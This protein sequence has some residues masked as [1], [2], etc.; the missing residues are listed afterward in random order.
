LVNRLAARLNKAYL[1]A[2]SNPNTQAYFLYTARGILQ[3]EISHALAIHFYYPSFFFITL[4]ITF[5]H[6][7]TR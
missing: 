1:L 5:R 7:R 3:Q 6:P 2:G 4:F